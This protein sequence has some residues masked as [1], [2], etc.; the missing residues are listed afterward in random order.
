MIG[1]A[2]LVLEHC[3]H[4]HG[5]LRDLELFGTLELFVLRKRQN[6]VKHGHSAKHGVPVLIGAK[7][8]SFQSS[9]G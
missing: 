4:N 2:S 6:M 3:K 8:A 1:M 9:Y 7:V 5:Q